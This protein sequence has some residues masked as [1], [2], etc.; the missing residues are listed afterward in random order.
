MRIQ[1]TKNPSRVKTKSVTYRAEQ[2]DGAAS[3]SGHGSVWPGATK[4]FAREQRSIVTPIDR[5]GA[6]VCVAMRKKAEPV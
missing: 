3:K 5:S 1:A 2:R 6:R 4:E